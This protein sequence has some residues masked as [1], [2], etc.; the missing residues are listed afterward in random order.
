MN[1]TKTTELTAGRLAR[2]IGTM[3]PVCLL[4]LS[5]HAVP[6]KPG[7][8]HFDN[9][10]KTVEVYLHGDENSH[11]Y[12]S[13]DGYMLM[14]GDDGIFR[15]ALPDGNGLRPSTFTATDPMHRSEDEISLLTSFS[16][17]TP[18]SIKEKEAATKGKRARRSS[19]RI[20]D[21]SYLNTFPTKGSPRCIA[22]LVEFQ[23][24]K[25]SL[26]EPQK[27]FS[28]MLNQEGFSR[29]GATGSARDYFM[30]SSGG[31]FNPQFDVYGPVTL[32]Y[33][34]SYYGGNNAQGDDA[35]PYEM[36][37][38]AVDLLRDKVDF[39]IYDTDNDDVVDN[40]YF[41]YAGYGEADGGPANSIWPHSWN[42]HDD[43]GMDIHMNGKLINHYATSN[44]LSNGAGQQLAGIGVF[45][46]EF[47]HVMGLPDLYSTTY[48]GAFTPGEWSL[49]DHGSYNNGSHTPPYHTG[50]ERYC[51]G[52][53]EPK[54]LSEPANITL[55][56]VSQVGT[57]DDVYI[58]HTE[59][60]S[61]YYL[62][63]NRQQKGWDEFIPGHGMLVW[64]I[65]FVPDIWNLNIV[66]IEKQHID[67][68]EAD[69]E[70]SEFSRGGDAFP[71]TAGVTELT[72]DTSPSM[73]SWSG[74]PLLSPITGI[75][76]HNGVITFAFK[77]GENIFGDIIAREPSE[78]RTSHFTASWE[79]NP[80]AT[81]YILSVYT[82]SKT[83]AKTEI[84]YL[85]GFRK[86][87]VGKV[88][89]FKVEGLQPETTYYYTVSVTNGRFYSPESNEVE[90]TTLPPT[91]DYMAVTALSASDVSDTSFRANWNPLADAGKYEVSLYRLE[92]GEA[93]STG[94]DFTGRELPSGWETDA[95][96]DG[97][98][99]YA[100]KTPSLRMTTEGSR[101]TTAPLTGIR[102]L[103]FWYR[104]NSVAEGSALVVSVLSNDEWKEIRTISPLVTAQG[105]ATVEITDIPS[106]SSRVRISFRRS[107]SGSVSIDDVKVGYGGN[108]TFAPVAGM[109]ALDAG[110]ECSLLIG[111]LHPDTNYGYSVTASNGELRSKP[112]EII[113]V[114]TATSGIGDISAENSGITIDGRTIRVD[115]IPSRTVTVTDLTGRLLYSGHAAGFRY[116]VPE[117][118]VY[119]I[120]I[121]NSACKTAIL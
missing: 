14:R 9:G 101:L 80:K 111:D 79:E 74:K 115:G 69:N 1:P 51:L 29:Y 102:S 25:F 99:S 64:H 121:G 59:K 78:I 90:A 6:A 50:Y 119:V 109:E 56:P 73:R 26:P 75:M 23:D 12:T 18:F 24:V 30:A 13:P 70:Q 85:E 60:Q 3:I 108:M 53:I 105:G 35:R 83:G 87:E 116:E 89:D 96:Y 28:D 118:G 107:E 21:E 81:G 7:P 5:A 106:P 93:F 49:M 52:W 38:H 112:S 98:S 76:E 2:T 55:Y 94:A 16:K 19:S 63:E 72:D 103:S 67:I 20:A 17:Q 8:M 32:P 54:V 36:V 61:E 100:V 66:N 77:G 48:T 68:V 92:L 86:R 4:A 27:L 45:C 44:E 120:R 46:H 10:G 39:S 37:P 95:S 11:Y 104:A 117:A 57:Y 97:R 22:V 15:Y 82:K 71:G 47:S 40:I 84:T 43:L 114:L 58:L 113:G 62:L 41:F 33:N 31:Q 110:S 34:M 88:T 42:I 65:D 91:L